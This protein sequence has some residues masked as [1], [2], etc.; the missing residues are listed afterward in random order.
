MSKSETEREDERDGEAE[1]S[2]SP[3]KAIRSKAT[4]TSK[5]AA[6]EK[7]KPADPKTEPEARR[8]PVRELVIGA[9][10][11]VG[12]RAAL[13]LLNVVLPTAPLAE[14]VIGALVVDVVAGR[15]GLE[16]TRPDETVGPQLRRAGFGA[17]GAALALGV[18][19]AL[20]AALGWARVSN[21]HADG[22]V[23]LA[24]VG[25]GAAAVRDELLLRG[26]PLM[27]AARVNIPKPAAIGFAALLSPAFALAD[28]SPSAG[29][30][31]LSIA[32]G[33]F[34]ASLYAYAG[35]APAAIGAHAAWLFGVGPLLRGVLETAWL[36]G[37]LGD[38]RA[39]GGAPA[40]VASAAFVLLA[41]AVPRIAAS[42]KLG[43]AA[44]AR[45]SRKAPPER[46][47]SSGA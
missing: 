19:V 18:A 33:L 43:D 39:A 42:A 1:P 6:V 9:L 8:S 44:D 10:V 46:A 5:K 21:G 2:E 27:F 34:F 40:F 7:Q 32:S 20:S 4:A 29:S 25:G 26:V 41:L 3:A 15:A 14:V 37:E 28:A 11:L 31:A 38:G 35:G 47:P 16:W 22:M 23:L 30:L 17:L 36:T 24:L 45:P 13:T 12:I